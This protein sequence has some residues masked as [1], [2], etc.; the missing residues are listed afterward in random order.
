MF[1]YFST[2]GIKML[3]YVTCCRW[4]LFPEDNFELVEVALCKKDAEW[5]ESTY[6]LSAGVMDGVRT[7][8]DSFLL[9]YLH[10]NIHV[11]FDSWYV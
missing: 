1:L 2:F 6:T 8:V 5:T 7:S 9:I 11:T 4:Y 10:L 3:F